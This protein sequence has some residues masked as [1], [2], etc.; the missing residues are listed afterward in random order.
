MTVQ[1]GLCRTWSETQI[2][3]FVTHRLNNIPINNGE[4]EHRS[5]HMHLGFDL[6]VGRDLV[7]DIEVVRNSLCCDGSTVV[8]LSDGPTCQEYLVVP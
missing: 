5:G 3:G 6:P 8:D 7:V 4:T 1:A 2:V